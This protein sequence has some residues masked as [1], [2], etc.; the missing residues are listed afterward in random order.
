MNYNK[1]HD[2]IIN[3]AKERSNPYCYTE[4]HHV[5]PRSM[6]GSDDKSNIV[7]LTAREHFIVH[8]LLSKIHRNNQM[9]FALF[10]MT[11]PGNSSQ[12]RYTSHSFKYAREKMAAMMSTLKSGKAHHLYGVKGEENPN[13]GSK[14]TDESKLRMS[15][16]MKG[17]KSSRA[18]SI[19]NIDT[20]ERF[21]SITEAKRKFSGNISYAL[22]T[23][24]T[25]NGFRF[26]Y[27]DG[28]E[29]KSELKG[30]AKG[31][32]HAMSVMVIN[33][34]TGEKFNTIKDAAI[35][36]NKTPPAI[37]WAMKNNKSICGFYFERI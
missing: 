19:I 29:W 1:I 17:R 22:K 27:D 30:I 4:G 34:T 35:S 37:Y 9:I 21:S 11:K 33:K 31:S 28:S 26:K 6:G 5:I 24:G 7:K 15:N 18:K 32:S 8:W 36:I 13:F 10:S 12:K 2:E 20:G 23:G 16:S 25:A 14:R 3:R